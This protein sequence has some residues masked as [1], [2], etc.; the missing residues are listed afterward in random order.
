MSAHVRDYAERIL[1]DLRAI[2]D[3]MAAADVVWGNAPGHHRMSDATVFVAE[4][5]DEMQSALEARDDYS[6]AQRVADAH[7]T[8]WDAKRDVA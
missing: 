1:C 2:Y 6:Q 3:R 8:A 4:A 5:C 7:A